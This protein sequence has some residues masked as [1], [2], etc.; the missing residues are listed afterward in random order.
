MPGAQD[1][2]YFRF[3]TGYILLIIPLLI[4]AFYK[5]KLIKNTII[6]FIRM[7]IQLI[8]VGL[9]LEYVFKLNY[10]WINLLWGLLM[11]TISAI[12]VGKRANM[13]RKIFILPIFIATLTSMIIIDMFFLG[14]VIKLNN[15]FDAMYFIPITGMILGNCL[16]TNIITL[17]TYY[18]SLH[19]DRTMYHFMIANGATQHEALMPFMRES[20]R[21]AFNPTIANTAVI[22]LI[23]LPGAM[24]G[25]LLGGNSPNIAIKYQIILIIAIFVA[26][27]LT[28]FL[29]IHIV[30]LFAFDKYHRLKTHL[31]NF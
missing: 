14:F 22:G 5:T 28:V 30:N 17:D 21:L 18:K 23:S 15:I 9:Y 26:S 8:L 25:Q 2:S 27:I 24:T 20:L 29:S 10:W 3:A 19:K 7:T 31:F 13:K 16:R 6:A 1:I 4:F 11:I 12:T